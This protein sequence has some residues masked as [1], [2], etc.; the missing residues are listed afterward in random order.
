MV[1]YDSIN[2]ALFFIS[3]FM[4]SLLRKC[5]LV[6][7]TDSDKCPTAGVSEDDYIILNYDWWN[8]LNPADKSWILSHETGHVAFRSSDRFK[9]GV[10]EKRN[11]NVATDATIN[12]IIK[13]FNLKNTESSIRDFGVSIQKLYDQVS[14]I[15]Q[16]KTSAKSAFNLTPDD[17]RIMTAE[18][19]YWIMDKY[20]PHMKMQG[21]GSSDLKDGNEG[22]GE[23]DGNG[24]EMQEGDKELYDG[25]NGKDGLAEKWKEAV[26][27]A[28][29]TQKAVGTVPAGI[30]RAISSMLEPKVN[31]KTLVKQAFVTGMG[32]TVAGTYRRPSRKIPLLPGLQRF[33]YP[34]VHFL[35][36]T[37]GSMGDQELSQ[38]LGEIYSAAK[39]SPVVVVPWDSESYEAVRA[40][41]QS[42]VI[43]KVGSAL[44]GGG[45][46][47]VGPVL[48]RTLEHMKPRDIVVLFTDGD[49]F[50]L[51]NEATKDALNAVA[52]RSAV[53]LFMTTHTKHNFPRWLTIK[54]DL[55]G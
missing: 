4:G 5:K 18:E 28:Y 42:E 27:N 25:K 29:A 44:K 10:M 23:S 46:T 51:D 40:S 16:T 47:V 31:W 34:T 15:V 11:W 21:S 8:S 22:N 55:H 6:I 7:T 33:T 37:S 45:G 9:K 49:I 43:S 13:E 36:D 14:S 30:E 2:T 41:T 53:A 19:I 35:V 1:Y 50:D 54:I 20:L 52:A 39:N 32:K 3:P 26:V 48:K 24:V 17:M 12:E 38:G